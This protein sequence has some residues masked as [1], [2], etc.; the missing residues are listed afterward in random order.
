MQRSIDP[1]RE[2]LSRVLKQVPQDTS[3]VMVKPR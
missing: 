1:D 3:I 2:Q